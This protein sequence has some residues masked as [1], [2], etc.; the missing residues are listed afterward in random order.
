MFEKR[1]AALVCGLAAVGVLGMGAGIASAADPMANECK[2]L[3]TGVNKF[4]I[5]TDPVTADQPADLS[6]GGLLC[7]S[8]FG[9]GKEVGFKSGT[10]SLPTGAKVR[11]ANPKYPNA[12]T[13]EPDLES[14]RYIGDV[15]MAVETVIA[16]MPLKL[17]NLHS[18]MYVDQAPP[19]PLG[20][21]ANTDCTPDAVACYQGLDDL[22]TGTA[23]T[24]VKKTD[25]GK[26]ELQ[27]K[28]PVAFIE[29][30]KIYFLQIGGT[31]PGDPKD[32]HLCRYAGAKNG[33]SCGTNPADWAQKNG[34]A[35]YYKCTIFPLWQWKYVGGS[36]PIKWL[37]VPWP[38]GYT[39]STVPSMEPK[40]AANDYSW[41][42]APMKTC[43]SVTWK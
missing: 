2:S 12:C 42:F 6:G 5:T 32:L 15:T 40:P 27:I 13:S 4:H 26:L 35:G 17:E 18:K 3:P 7:G 8:D 24:I 25:K 39:V 21:H 1:V 23:N 29:N 9:G 11:C 30:T 20:S 10:I 34:P 28:T 41:M 43:A 31:S 16:G 19:G 37:M 36:A 22:G 33:S 38:W 14:G